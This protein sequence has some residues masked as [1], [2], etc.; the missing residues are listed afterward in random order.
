MLSKEE[1]ER[2]PPHARG[3]AVYMLGSRPDQPHV[4]NESNPYPP[5]SIDAENWDAGQRMA[6]LHAQDM[7]E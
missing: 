7:D 2:M 1:F 3:Y 5:G 4:P 6:I